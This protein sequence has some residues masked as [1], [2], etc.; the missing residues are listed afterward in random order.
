M[1]HVWETHLPPVHEHDGLCQLLE[2]L[3]CNFQ[4]NSKILGALIVIT[5][6]VKNAGW[7]MLVIIVSVVRFIVVF[8]ARMLSVN[9]VALME[10]M[11][12]MIQY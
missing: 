7:M 5:T 2:V 10:R 9:H 4:R 3:G 11:V 12:A 8:S 6:I 1:H